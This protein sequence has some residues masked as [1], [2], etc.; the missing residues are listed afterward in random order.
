MRV[1]AWTDLKQ[2]WSEF[3]LG[4][5]FCAEFSAVKRLQK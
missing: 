4:L 3:I 1:V 2:G 5:S